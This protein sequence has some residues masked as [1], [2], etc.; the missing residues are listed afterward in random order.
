M[1]EILQNKVLVAATISAAIGQFSKPFTSSIFNRTALDF[2]RAF[3]AGGFPSSHSSAIVATATALGFERGLSDSVFG[4]AVVCAGLVMYDAQGVRR[5]VGTHAK[6][7]NKVL[8]HEKS[9]RDTDGFRDSLTITSSDSGF[10]DGN[11]V[12]KLGSFQSEQRSGSVLVE[13]AATR[14]DFERKLEGSSFEF[15]PLKESVGHTEIEVMAGA[16]LGL[17]V[18]LA[19]CVS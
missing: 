6:A 4:L 1:A 11:S 5:E 3:Q 12:E 2:R 17:F 13:S 8:V 18:S 9:K 19:L 14:T 7:F 16:L 10:V 15:T